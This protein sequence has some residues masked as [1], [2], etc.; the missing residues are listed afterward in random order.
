[1]T[2]AVY[3]GRFIRPSN[4]QGVDSGLQISPA[5]SSKCR[6]LSGLKGTLPHLSAFWKS[7][8]ADGRAGHNV[9]GFHFCRRSYC[10]K[11]TDRNR[12]NRVPRGRTIQSQGPFFRGCSGSPEG[13]ALAMSP[14]GSRRIFPEWL[15]PSA[16]WS[17]I[18][19]LAWRSSSGN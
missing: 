7:A 5:G 15:R 3:S 17:V 13:S 2:P 4:L 12:N 14:P 6:C 11:D 8:R 16:L 18:C 10:S 9:R 1:M 19:V